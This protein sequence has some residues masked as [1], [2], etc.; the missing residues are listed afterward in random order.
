MENKKSIE[1]GLKKPENL[2]VEETAP[3]TSPEIVEANIEIQSEQ[4]ESKQQTFETNLADLGG[5]K[6]V[7]KVWSELDQAK[8]KEIENNIAKFTKGRKEGIDNQK[9]ALGILNPG[10]TFGALS[11]S[12][13]RGGAGFGNFF[14][15]LFTIPAHVLPTIGSP[16]VGLA[17]T[18]ERIKNSI[19]LNKEKR[20]LSKLEKQYQ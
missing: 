18:I 14:G 19:K 10:N 8:K 17:G 4:L 12:I 15:A 5:E 9:I 13:N 2:Y 16:F 6:G 1:G 11:E 20:K 7:Q 3:E